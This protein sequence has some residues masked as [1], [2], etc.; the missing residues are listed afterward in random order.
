MLKKV[1]LAVLAVVVLVVGVFCVVVA[2]QPTDF[3]ITRAATFNATPDKVFEQVNDFH[4][5]DA[6]SPWAKID[7][8]MKTSYSGPASGAGASYA[9]V[10]NSDVGE[11]KMTITESH[12]SA[13]IKIDLDFIAPFAAKNV[14][15][16][17]FK[18][19]GDKTIAT[20]LMAG[21]KNFIMKA[22]CMFMDMDKVVG[23]DF[24]KGLAQ[25]KPVVESAPKQ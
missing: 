6:W 5:W 20:W 25:M 22:I 9:W 13:H 4:K 3:K 12:P 23:G 21:N 15:E 11:G 18:P 17:T 8:A 16:F 7:P 19:E 14:T 2:M 1:V 24:E 10:G